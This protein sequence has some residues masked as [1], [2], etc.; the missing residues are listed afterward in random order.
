M[1]LMEIGTEKG[2][3]K[4]ISQHETALLFMLGI[5]IQ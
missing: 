2:N 1:K 4:A 5:R 3:V